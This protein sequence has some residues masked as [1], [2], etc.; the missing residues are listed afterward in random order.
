MSAMTAPLRFV[1]LLRLRVEHEYFDGGLARGL[2]FEHEPAC[3]AW[4]GRHGLI[5]R[6]RD[7]AL[8][9]AAA[10]PQLPALHQELRAAATL[11]Q[12]LLAW[13]LLAADPAHAMYTD[14][15]TPGRVAAGI[16]DL[17][18][19]DA[20]AAALPLRTTLRLRSRL[21]TWKYLLLGDWPSHPIELVERD[22]RA[23]FRRDEPETLDDGR[24]AAVFRSTRR[25]PLR[26][27]G[28][29]HLELRET[30]GASRRLLTPVPLAAPA[31]L[32]C[33]HRKGRRRP[34]HEIFLNR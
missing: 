12:D 24:V 14:R 5:A 15:R 8:L 27:R 19:L 26:E 3:A 33:E 9:L 1:E 11:G 20:W 17:P 4:L 21:S 13:R 25:L 16:G 7:G 30:E 2:R 23:V 29:L 32:I 6:Q 34:V 10:E 31:G 22:G 18:G 28:A